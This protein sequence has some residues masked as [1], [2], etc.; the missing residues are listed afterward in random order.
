MNRLLMIF[1]VLVILI[2]SSVT[3]ALA[4]KICIPF[5][6]DPK[7]LQESFAR[8]GKKLDLSGNDKDNN[9]WGFLENKGQ[10]YI[11]YTYKPVEKEDFEILLK[12]PMEVRIGENNDFG[13]DK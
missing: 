8:N 10:E 4:D 9:S 3:D 1:W 12:V 7:K 5:E 11:I 2:L 6:C 13:P